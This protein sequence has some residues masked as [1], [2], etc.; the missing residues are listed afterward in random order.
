MTFH[1][2]HLFG[3]L[4]SAPEEHVNSRSPGFALFLDYEKEGKIHV[5]QDEMKGHGSYPLLLGAIESLGHL[6][7][8]HCEVI[9]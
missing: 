1:F 9:R 6:G 5:K 2:D 8:G 4:T 3:D 7:E